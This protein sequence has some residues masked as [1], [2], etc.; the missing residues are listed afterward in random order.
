MQAVD[1]KTVEASSVFLLGLLRN[2]RPAIDD[3]NVALLSHLLDSFSK[4][5]RTFR[6]AV[7]DSGRVS[8][9]KLGI[10]DE[11]ID[12]GRGNEQKF[13]VRPVGRGVG[14]VDQRNNGVK[15][16]FKLGDSELR[17]TRGQV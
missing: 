3:S 2:R 6:V 13:S 4:L 17:E 1:Q 10:A 9:S 7:W 5:S 8:C 16:C 14:R 11:R 15:V 12:R